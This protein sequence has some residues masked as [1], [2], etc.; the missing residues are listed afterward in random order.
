MTSLHGVARSAVNAATQWAALASS[1]KFRTPRPRS[2]SI[3]GNQTEKVSSVM[4]RFLAA[5]HRASLICSLNCDKAFPLTGDYA[6]GGIFNAHV[7]YRQKDGNFVIHYSGRAH[8][9]LLACRVCMCSPPHCLRSVRS[10]GIASDEAGFPACV[11]IDSGGH[12]E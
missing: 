7:Y 2:P 11:W 3:S 5:P 1:Q 10:F 6:L 8:K 9:W 12:Y 4:R